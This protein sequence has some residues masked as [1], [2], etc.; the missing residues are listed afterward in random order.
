[1][2]NKSWLRKELAEGGEGSKPKGGDAVPIPD[3]DSMDE[4][5]LPE[6]SPKK[7]R[8]AG[9]GAGG[10]KRRPDTA[11]A[12]TGAGIDI[13]QTELLLESHSNRILKAQKANLEGM[14]AIFEAKTEEKF[15]Q[16]EVRAEA[17]EDRVHRV[18]QRLQEMHDKMEQLIQGGG[19]SLATA[20]GDPGAN[21]RMTLIFG[22]WNRDTRKQTILTS[23]K[24]LN[25]FNSKISSTT[26][27]SRQGPG[28]AQR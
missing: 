10:S 18:E 28:E 23:T 4:S 25:G 22:G 12:S 1:M 13:A 19:E 9:P 3:E 17:T 11:T 5:D 8:H 7:S 24:H 27:P 26:R 21:R 14:M 2:S 6:G 20:G 15:K 16:Q